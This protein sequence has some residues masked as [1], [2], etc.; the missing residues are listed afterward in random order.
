V[1][2]HPRTLKS[3]IVTVRAEI[4]DQ[5]FATAIGSS[6]FVQ[7]PQTEAAKRKPASI[8]SGRLSSLESVE[9]K[10]EQLELLFLLL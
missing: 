10:K 5:K 8:Y 1:V 3:M 6:Q 4:E 2:I 7:A 9:H